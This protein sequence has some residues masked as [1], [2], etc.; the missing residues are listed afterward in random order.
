[1]SSPPQTP[2]PPRDDEPSGPSGPRRRRPRG[3]LRLLAALLAAGLLALA[4]WF[5]ASGVDRLADGL[6][7]PDVVLSR[8]EVAARVHATLQREADAAFLVTGRLDVLATAEVEN[9]RTVLPGLLDLSMGTSRAT[10]RVPGTVWY[11]V[12]LDAFSAADVEVE[13]DTLVRLRLPAPEVQAVEP[14][15]SSMDVRTE[16]GWARLPALSE[17][18]AERAA[19]GLVADVLR[20]QGVAHL[21]DD[22]DAGTRTARALVDLLRP[23]L[24]E[25]GAEAPVFHVVLG[26]RTFV[27]RP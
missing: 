3:T 19:L 2:H 5:F 25:A 15:L 21:A 10:V 12:P 16:R 18:D 17:R 22:P 27:V 1:M 20:R 14:D 23:V 7:P 13:A 11:G 24:R 8:E 4:A 9:T 6:R 26:G